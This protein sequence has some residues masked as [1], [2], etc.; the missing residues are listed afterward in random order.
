[1]PNALA[2]EIA[3]RIAALPEPSTD[4]VR[5]VRREY[6]RL[7]ASASPSE[8]FAVAEALLYQPLSHA[9]RFVAYELIMSHPLAGGALDSGRVEWLARDLAD[10]GAVDAFSCLVAG[11]AWRLGRIDD[12]V[13][14]A[15]A[16]STDR[17]WKRAAL[18]CTTSLNV[19]GT[20]GDA[21]RT[22]RIVALLAADR[23]PMVVKAMSWALRELSKRDP[24]AVR[25]FLAGHQVAPHVVREVNSKLSTGLKRVPTA[26][27]TH[28]PPGLA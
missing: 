28:S 14:A 26:R 25:E 2:E 11:P 8:V 27:R 4:R 22:L 24:D 21:A 7:I 6:S 20:D 13:I 19:L 17:W 1:V 12:D 23:D 5:Q 15:W 16:T 18:V 10:W 3:Q 9:R